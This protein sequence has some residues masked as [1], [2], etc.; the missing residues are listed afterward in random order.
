MKISNLKRGI[1]DGLFP[2]SF[3]SN[4]D[5]LIV[6]CLLY[7]FIKRSISAEGDNE[8]TIKTTARNYAENYKNII[9]EFKKK[10]I[11]YTIMVRRIENYNKESFLQF[12][13]KEINEIVQLYQDRTQLIPFSINNFS[14]YMY[15]I[16]NMNYSQYQKLSQNHFDVMAPIIRYYMDN[17][18]LNDSDLE[19]FDAEVYPGNPGKGILFSIKDITPSKI[20]NDIKSNNIIIKY[21]SLAVVQNY[22]KIV[23]N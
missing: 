20:I 18:N 17:Y 7:D 12:S 1:Y 21:Y 15:R 4:T 19:V 2:V 3:E 9:A 16:A 6:S 10:F 14:Q 13:E 11:S 8:N 5:K 23:L 22:V